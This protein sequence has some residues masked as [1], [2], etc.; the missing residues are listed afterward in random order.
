MKIENKDM[1]IINIS[2]KKGYNRDTTEFNGIKLVTGN[3]THP[4]SGPIEDNEYEY[5][6][7]LKV[8]SRVKS[9]KPVMIE[10]G[11]FWAVWSLAF[12]YKFPTGKNIL[13]ELG[14]R[15]LTIG[16]TNFELNNFDSIN[17]HG[18]FFL[19]KSGTFNNKVA[20]LEYDKLEDESDMVGPE[21]DFLEIYEEQKL[22]VIDLIHMDI[23]GSELLL[24]EK[25]KDLLSKRKILNLVIAT[26]SQSIHS[27]ILEI[28]TEN[29]FDILINNNL[30]AMGADGHIYANL[31]G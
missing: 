1:E 21:L 11:C 23:Q 25:L 17:Y 14:K 10:V 9:E 20:D 16:L 4:G 22:D 18:G 19:E 28:L 13:I 6:L 8:L 30:G 31:K 15:Q 7:F 29:G 2:E 27:R 26:H 24:V 3:H 5:I 12:R